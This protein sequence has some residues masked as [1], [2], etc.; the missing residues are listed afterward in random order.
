MNIDRFTVL[1]KSVR[2]M[3]KSYLKQLDLRKDG[4]DISFSQP[5]VQPSDIDLTTQIRPTHYQRAQYIGA[6]CIVCMP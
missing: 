3:Y 4:D 6:V 2:H 5:I 1:H